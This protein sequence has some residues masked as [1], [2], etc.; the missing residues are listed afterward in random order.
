[1]ISFK[2]ATLHNVYWQLLCTQF[3]WHTYLIDRALYKI[4]MISYRQK[5]CT[6]FADRSSVQNLI[7]ILLTVDLYTIFTDSCWLQNYIFILTELC[8]K[9]KWHITDSSSVCSGYWQLLCTQFKWHITDSS[10][11]HNLNDNLL[12]VVLCT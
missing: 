12:T 6:H 5:L 2:T 4:Q 3:R 9:F 7:Y 10:Y 8:T 11:V 1:M